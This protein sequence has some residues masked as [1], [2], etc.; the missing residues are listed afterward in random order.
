MQLKIG[1]WSHCLIVHV[2]SVDLSSLAVTV[3]SKISFTTL[4]RF[5]VSWYIFYVKSM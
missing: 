1:P 4:S 2:T 3:V 5:S